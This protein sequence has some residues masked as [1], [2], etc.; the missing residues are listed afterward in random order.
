[1]QERRFTI[2]L[3]YYPFARLRNRLCKC[4]TS[5]KSLSILAFSYRLSYS[6]FG[7]HTTRSAA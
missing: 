4:N 6:F 2:Q 5:L 1:M 3:P 7:V